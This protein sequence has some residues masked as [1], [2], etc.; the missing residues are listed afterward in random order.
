MSLILEYCL[1]FIVVYRICLIRYNIFEVLLIYVSA[2][3]LVRALLNGKLMNRVDI[4]LTIQCISYLTLS[5][6]KSDLLLDGVRTS[7]AEGITLVHQGVR[8]DI[9]GF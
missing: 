5:E 8:Q 6:V 3:L 4:L 2:R 9:V 7:N 1:Q